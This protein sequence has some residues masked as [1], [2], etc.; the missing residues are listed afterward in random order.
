MR[1]LFPAPTRSVKNIKTWLENN[2]G[3]IMEAEIAFIER[4]EELVSMCPPKSALRR[5]FE[6]HVVWKLGIFNIK[7][8]SRSPLS[9]SESVTYTFDDRAVDLFGSLSAFVAAS[10]MLIAP[11]WILESLAT[12]KQ[13]LGVITIFILLFLGFLTLT[14]L[15]RPFERL[16]ATAG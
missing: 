6:D 8:Y 16:A 14:T 1:Q 11:L 13:K 12:L 10:A 9:E 4:S 2:K 7:A 3:A 5:W 15:G